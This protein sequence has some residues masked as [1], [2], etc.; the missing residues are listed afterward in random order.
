MITCMN[1]SMFSHTYIYVCMYIYICMYMYMYMYISILDICA[2]CVRVRVCVRGL[3][4]RCRYVV[5]HIYM[6]AWNSQK[7]ICICVYM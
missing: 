6:R 2:I 4:H 3:R 7:C 5:L 1:I